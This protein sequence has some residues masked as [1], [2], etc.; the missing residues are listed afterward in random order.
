MWFWWR[1]TTGTATFVRGR[2]ERGDREEEK[3]PAE[4]LS[5]RLRV[6]VRIAR[7]GEVMRL[8]RIGG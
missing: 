2:E 7:N 8:A 1:L 3:V 6:E 4:T 5:A